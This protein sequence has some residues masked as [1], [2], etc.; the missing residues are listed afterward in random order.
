MKWDV[1]IVIM[2]LGEK[3]KSSL[4]GFIIFCIWVLTLKASCVALFKTRIWNKNGTWLG[5]GKP[6]LVPA[7]LRIGAKLVQAWKLAL[8]YHLLFFSS[9]IC[10]LQDAFMIVFKLHFQGSL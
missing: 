5:S 2:C 9:I 3:R 6:C 4:L 1:K 10:I 8:V 7:L